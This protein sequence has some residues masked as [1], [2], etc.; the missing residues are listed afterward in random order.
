MDPL[1]PGDVFAAWAGL[2]PLIGQD[3]KAPTEIS[4]QD[5]VWVGPAGVV[6]VAG[7]KLTGYRPMAERAV[8]CAVAEAGLRVNE[9][10]SE[11]DPLPGGEGAEDLEALA[12]ALARSHGCSAAMADRL[13]RSYGAEATAVLDRG[14]EP[15]AGGATIAAGEVAWAVEMEDALHLEDFLVRRTR[16]ALYD[17]AVS[18]AIEPAAAAMAGQL[19]WS[20]AMREAEI[21]GMRARLSADLEFKHHSKG[22]PEAPSAKEV[23]A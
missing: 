5:E 23:R 3:G 10:A 11:P 12:A 6:T 1:G 21:A 4:R 18:E 13:V 20:D 9:V 19:G 15:L 17:P 7:G 8:A 22:D 2:R 14:A 16:A